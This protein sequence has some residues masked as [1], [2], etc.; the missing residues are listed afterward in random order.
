MIRD[1]RAAFD[2]LFGVGATPAERAAHRKTDKSILDWVS[3]EVARLQKDLGAGDRQRLGAYL[4][5][6]R[7]VERRVQ[8][9]T[10]RS[11]AAP[12][13][14]LSVAP[15]QSIDEHIKLMYDL[16]FLAFQGDITRVSAML[17]VRDESGTSYPESGV[18]TAHHGA[19]H[20]G[21]DTVKREDYAKIN[22]YHTKLLAYFLKKMKDWQA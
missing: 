21:E 9:S 2:S 20:H 15:P 6:V 22:R 7:E 14:E 4:E 18:T 1:P 10:S 19:S 3:G 12:S 5:E 17:L 13:L 8:L 11:V 16:Q